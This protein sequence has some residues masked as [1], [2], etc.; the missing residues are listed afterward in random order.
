MRSLAVTE[1]TDLER[2]WKYGKIC[3]E[4]YEVGQEIKKHLEKHPNH[5][6]KLVP[7]GEKNEGDHNRS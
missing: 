2:I 4:I 5:N 7:K 1:M 3:R 6:I